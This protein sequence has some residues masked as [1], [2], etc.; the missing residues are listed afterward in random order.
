MNILDNA[1]PEHKMDY[2]RLIYYLM[3]MNHYIENPK[4]FVEKA[5]INGQ[6]LKDIFKTIMINLGLGPYLKQ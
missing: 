6:T 5:K 2:N 4:E 3:Q 1:S